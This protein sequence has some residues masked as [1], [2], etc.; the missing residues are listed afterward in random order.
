MKTTPFTKICLS[1]ISLY[2]ILLDVFFMLQRTMS[3]EQSQ[4]PLST[5]CSTPHLPTTTFTTPVRIPF[6]TTT[7][8][9]FKT[10]TVRSYITTSVLPST[11]Q[12]HSYLT[13]TCS[14]K[15]HPVLHWTRLPAP[16][17]IHTSWTTTITTP[18]WSWMETTTWT[19]HLLFLGL[20]PKLFC[21]ASDRQL[22]SKSCSLRTRWEDHLV[23]L[24]S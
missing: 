12:L 6:K 2:R 15:R 4:C 21:W 7:L 22:V 3:W 10:I 1:L 19:G 24:S 16:T 13:M 18:K 11:K 14:T 23:I 9:R 20:L 17:L 5:I 8:L